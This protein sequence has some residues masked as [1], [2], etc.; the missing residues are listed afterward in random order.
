MAILKLEDCKFCMER[1]YA[2]APVPG[3]GNLNLAEV[4]FLGRNPGRDEDLY[5][6]PFIGQAGKKLNEGLLYAGIQRNSV[7]ITN[8]S[9][10]MTPTGIVPSPEC[11]NKCA[12]AWLNDEL[13]SLTR[14][15][16]IVTLGNQ[17]LQYFEPLDH[18]HKSMR[19]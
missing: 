17:A 3:V 10:C 7:Y 18:S 1:R 16:V 6:I 15:R 11:L 14:L 4:C 5:S 8:I 12:H 19:P 9:K 2:N 13:K